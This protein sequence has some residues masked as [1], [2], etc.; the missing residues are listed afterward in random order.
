[1]VVIGLARGGVM[2]AAAVAQELR[3]PLGVVVVRKVGAPENPELAL[4]AITAA[5]ESFFNH[6]LISLLEVSKEYL[7]KETERQKKAARERTALYCR[8]ISPPPLANKSVIL[9]DDGIATGA[10][11]KAAILGMRSE[12]V[13]GIILAVPVAA[14]ESLREM[15]E[16]VDQIVCLYV[17]SHFE[18]VGFFYKEFDQVSDEAIIALLAQKDV[19]KE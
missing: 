14:K 10:S 16:D 6:D 1:V 8:H 2:T 7:L 11:M 5:G 19:R 17:P 3:L 18:A 4:G 15:Q 9:V 12:G 13:K